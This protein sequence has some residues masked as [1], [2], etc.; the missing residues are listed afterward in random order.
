MYMYA[1]CHLTIP[2][3]LANTSSYWCQQSWITICRV[4]QIY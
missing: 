3:T 1:K 4:R 2:K